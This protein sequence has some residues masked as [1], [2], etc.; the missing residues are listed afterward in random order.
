[1]GHVLHGHG[2]QKNRIT[3]HQHAHE[4]AAAFTGHPHRA[5]VGNLHHPAAG[6]G[7]L[8][9]GFLFQLQ[10][11]HHMRRDAEHQR[12]GVGQGRH[13]QGM[14]LGQARIAQRDRGLHVAHAWI[15]WKRLG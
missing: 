12:A 14:Q 8:P 15:D 13:L 5:H 11:H 9:Q 7:D 2:T 10:L 6:D 4:T 1:M 3:Q